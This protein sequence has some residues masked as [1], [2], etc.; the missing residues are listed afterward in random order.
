M[1]G[2]SS[3]PKLRLGALIVDV[4]RSKLR[5]KPLPAFKS[6]LLSDPTKP[7]RCQHGGRVT[8]VRAL[9]LQIY[10]TCAVF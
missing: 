4:A 10:R 2:P 5:S 6:L 1:F 3:Q 9:R 7:V 8:T